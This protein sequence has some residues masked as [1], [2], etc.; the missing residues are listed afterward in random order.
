MIYDLIGNCQNH[1]FKKLILTAPNTSGHL[2]RLVHD[3]NLSN[4]LRDDTIILDLLVHKTILRLSRVIRHL[5]LIVD[6]IIH[7][8]VLT[9][10]LHQLTD[11]NATEICRQSGQ[12]LDVSAVLVDRRAFIVRVRKHEDVLRNDLARAFGDLPDLVIFPDESAFFG[13]RATFGNEPGHFEYLELAVVIIP[14]TTTISNAVYQKG[15]TGLPTTSLW[16]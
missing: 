9:Q 11:R 3:P 2:P 10:L 8:P 12:V 1:S 14:A 13:D 15:R 7:L 5:D 16:P 6:D 4:I